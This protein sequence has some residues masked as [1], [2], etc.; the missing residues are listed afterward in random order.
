MGKA[1]ENLQEAVQEGDLKASIELL[2]IT[3]MHGSVVN[4]L[5]ETDPEKIMNMARAAREN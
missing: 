1:V 3:G 4:V 5:S 2:K